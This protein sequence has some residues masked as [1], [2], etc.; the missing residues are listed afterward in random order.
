VVA[1][2]I[3]GRRRARASVPALREAAEAGSDIYL[4]AAALRSVIEIEGVESLRGWL[5]DLSR[6]GPFN[7]RAIARQALNRT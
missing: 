5:N 4:R 2:K 7:V 1:A 3:L 6:D